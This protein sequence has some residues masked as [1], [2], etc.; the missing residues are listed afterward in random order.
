VHPAQ[1]VAF[2][3]GFSLALAAGCDAGQMS[4]T[5]ASA[6]TGGS[7]G[8]ASASSGQ[9]TSSSSSGGGAPAS[10]L[11]VS[12]NKLVDNGLPV[13]LLGVNRSGTEFLCIQGSGFVDG[14]SDGTSVAD[15]KA[16]HI[17]T[18]RVPLNED[19]WL[20]INGAP[21]AGSYQ[22]AISQWVSTLRAGGLYV[23]LDLHWNDPDGTKATMQQDMADAD[24]APAFWMGV[25][26][27]F[28]DDL[29]ILFDLYNEPHDISWS[30][31]KDSTS[32]Q[33]NATHGGWPIAGMNQLIAAVRGTGAKNVLMAGGVMFAGDL[34]QWL[35][36][37]PTDPMGNL[38][39][40]FHGYNFSNCHDMG[41][42]T[43]QLASVAAQVPLITGELGQNCDAAN[44]RFQGEP[45]GAGYV[46]A[47]MSWAD[48]AGVSYLG[49]AWNPDFSACMGPSLNMTGKWDG[50]APT[51]PFGTDFQAHLK[52]V[53]P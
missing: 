35:A 9:G 2:P 25:A 53:G 24:H 1:R 31:W 17:N 6:G 36:N 15:M 48:T 52:V 44:Q 46:S 22:G 47:F 33:C 29:G 45:A 34:S 38:A 20:G 26:S 4:R 27:T 12:G 11:Q 39:A 42:W 30:C 14:P 50:T 5:S 3:V 49:W 32:G 28:K 19:C 21:A 40:S 23:I 10:T 16:W 7:G 18:V 41:C 43:S 51:S 37:K 8:G 13:R